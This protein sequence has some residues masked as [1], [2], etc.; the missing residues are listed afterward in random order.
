V[1]VYLNGMEPANSSGN[2]SQVR[3]KL[4]TWYK[5]K[6]CSWSITHLLPWRFILGRLYQDFSCGNRRYRL[7]A[8]ANDAAT[9]IMLN[10]GY[11]YYPSENGWS[12][13]TTIDFGD[14]AR[15]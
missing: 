4:G 2:H 6:G 11:K 14:L 10:D 1:L 8:R 12:K 15:R 5:I 3:A 9:D 7:Y 13:N